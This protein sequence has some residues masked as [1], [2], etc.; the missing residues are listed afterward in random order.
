MSTDIHK[1]R[2]KTYSKVK[3]IHKREK[4]M[5]KKEQRKKDIN[6]KVTK[7]KRSKK[8]TTSSKKLRKISKKLHM[9]CLDTFIMIQ[10]VNPA[11]ILVTLF[12][13]AP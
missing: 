13:G 4:R 3:N 8:K 11:N 2:V 10:S 6:V 1:V 5:S 12:S 9:D 7:R